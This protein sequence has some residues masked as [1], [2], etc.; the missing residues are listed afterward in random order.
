MTGSKI[1]NL[2]FV[3]D[4][5][6]LNNVWLEERVIF[7]EGDGYEIVPTTIE[8]YRPELFLSGGFTSGKQNSKPNLNKLDRLLKEGPESLNHH[9]SLLDRGREER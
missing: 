3:F 2:E 4:R 7:E 8:Y 5:S 1:K 9:S 6:R